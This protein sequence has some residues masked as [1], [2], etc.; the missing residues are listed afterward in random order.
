M[1][2]YP[3]LIFAV[4]FNWAF[5][6]LAGMNPFGTEMAGTR[7]TIDWNATILAMIGAMGA[8]VAATIITH[9]TFIQLTTLSYIVIF[10]GVC[11]PLMVYNTFVAIEG[12]Y[13]NPATGTTLF[14]TVIKDVITGVL[15]IIAVIAAIQSIGGPGRIE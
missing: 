12:A 1:R 7:I 6:I 11:G 15:A 13:I 9:F 14:P 5:V 10:L 3:I 4:C 2:L 8:L